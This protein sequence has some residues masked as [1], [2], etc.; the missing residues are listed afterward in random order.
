MI[1]RELSGSISSVMTDN[2]AGAHLAM[3]HLYSLGHR[4]IAFIRGPKMLVDSSPRCV[5]CVRLRARW[6]WEIDP[7]W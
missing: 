3:E 7:A 1:G 6:A 4:K 5:V 2:E